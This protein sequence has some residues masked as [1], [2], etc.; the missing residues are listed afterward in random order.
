MDM[1]V[2]Y[3]LVYL[4]INLMASCLILF[5]RYKT[6]G[7]SQMVSQKT[8][9]LAIDAEIVFF[10]SDTA[11]VMITTGLVPGGS[12]G[13]MVAKTVYFFFTGLMCFCWFLYFEHLQGSAFTG[14]RKTVVACS[15][16]VWVL[17]ILL[18]V[19]LF[20]GMLFFV[21][22]QGVYRRGPLF[23]LQYLLAYLYVLLSCGHA[24]AG[25]LHEKN[26]NR[27]RLLLSLALFPIAPAAAGILQFVLPQIPAACFALSFATLILYQN[28]LDDMISIDPLTRLNNRK[29][30][31]FYYEQW[32]RRNE[33]IPLYLL[34]ID[35]NRFKQINDTYGHVQGDAALERIA[36]ALRTASTGMHYRTNI[37]RYGGDEFAMLVRSE[38]SREITVLKERIHTSLAQLNA[39]APYELS[40]SVGMARAEKDKP[41]KQLIEEADAM[42][43]EEKEKSRE[44]RNN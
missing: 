30:L 16:L 2:L 1:R 32:S 15:A 39:G 6:L 24:L 18:I 41:L 37:A 10:L 8:F 26:R 27:R 43:Y 14:N 5:I 42:L 21:D 44:E 38:D 11:A 4:E 12:F 35:A 31:L 33:T 20:T 23:I 13:I 25:L 19:N 40:V 29:M 7:I 36:D 22:Q 34:L 28:W 9:S 3:G 17:G